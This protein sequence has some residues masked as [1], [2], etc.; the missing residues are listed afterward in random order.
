MRRLI[1]WLVAAVVIAGLIWAFLPQPVPV[2]L[3]EVGPRDIAVTVEEEG[4]ARI[5]EVYTVSATIGGKLNRIDLHAGDPV[6]ARETTVAL[7]G[8]SAPALLDARARAVAEAGIEA[9]LAAVDLAKAQLMQAEA[10]LEFMATE[11]RRSEQ[12]FERSAI[13]QRMYDNAVLD[14]KTAEAARDSASAN[15]AVR[16]R[17]L[18]SAR[19]TLDT[20]GDRSPD[21]CCVRLTAPVSG[22]V[23]KVITEDE[24]VVVPGQPI[25]EIGNPANLEIVVELLS[26]DAV[27]VG[28]RA[29]AVITGWGGPPLS[30]HVSR[31]HPSA[32]T[33]VSALGIDEQRVEVVLDLEGSA[34][35]RHLL[36]HGFRV[37]AQIEIWKGEDILAIPIGA[38][39]RDGADWVTYVAADGRAELRSITL[40]ARNSEYAEVMDGLQAGEQV[41]LHPSD[42]VTEGV[43]IS[44]D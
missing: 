28:N 7:I 38:L 30:A 1:P 2:E 39:F 9:A 31:V 14:R 19:A 41:I 35:D 20:A 4:E 18:E 27:R 17:E 8:P 34:E 3:A 33:T 11:A 23:L 32:E 12:L 29:K 26:R 44:A 10:T 42:Q 43:R 22:R 13:S 40:G 37:I 16:E 15:L 6:A 21:S 25:L 5:R 36:G 24:Q